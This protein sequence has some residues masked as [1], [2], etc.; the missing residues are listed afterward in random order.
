MDAQ[1]QIYGVLLT[2]E[3]RSNRLA[4]MAEAVESGELSQDQASCLIFGDDPYYAWLADQ[5]GERK[6]A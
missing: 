1:L 6:A 3:E 2:S 5:S 4:D